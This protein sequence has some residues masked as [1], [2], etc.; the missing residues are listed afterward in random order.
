[1]NIREWFG[2]S[3]QYDPSTGFNQS[4]DDLLSLYANAV[5]QY[6][7]IDSVPDVQSLLIEASGHRLT[8]G[9]RLFLDWFESKGLPSVQSL[10]AITCIND[11]QTAIAEINYEAYILKEEMDFNY[12][13]DVRAS[14]IAISNELQ[15][16]IKEVSITTEESSS[17]FNETFIVKDTSYKWLTQIEY[18][19][20]EF[21]IPYIQMESSLES[22]LY[23]EVD[24]LIP[25]KKNISIK[26]P[27]N[28]Q[29]PFFCLEL[30]IINC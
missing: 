23:L 26:E 27:V 13:E 3:V 18:V 6:F 10:S 22:P 24:H 29:V 14:L 12:P 1:M 30:T 15:S 2:C 4:L 28:M 21:T 17:S 16:I 11:E 7:E 5:T 19:A 20:E 9:Q 8:K 25:D